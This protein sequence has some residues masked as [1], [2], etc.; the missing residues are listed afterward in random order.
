MPRVTRRMNP[1]LTT[2][3]RKVAA[4]EM[5]KDGWSFSMSELFEPTRLGDI[6]VRNKIVMA[7]LTRQRADAHGVPAPFAV[8]YYA[9]RA[10]AGLIITEGTQ[11][12][13]E[14]QGYPRTPGAHTPA[15]SAAW[16]RITDAVHA[17]GGK[18]VLQMMH[19][20]RIAHHLNRQVE[21]PPVA[22][23]A[24]RA[25]GTIWTD[26]LQQQ[27]H[28]VPRALDLAEIPRL[29]DDFVH[30]ARVA[31]EAGFDGVE[32]HA[33]N[34]YLINQFLATNANQRSDRYGG[35]VEGR[36]RLA[37]EA[38]DAIGGAIGY[39]RTGIRISPG[40]LFN[41]LVDADPRA[42][43]AALL[44]ALPTDKMAY[45]HLM[46]PDSFDPGL[47]NA[48]DV[49]SLIADIR[50]RVR[51]PIILAGGFDRARAEAA[52]AAGAGQ[53]IA[54]GRPFIANPDFVTRLKSGAPL[55]AP[56]ADLFYTPGPEGYTD[57]PALG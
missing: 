14:G 31:I 47:N 23:S 46:S 36:I 17:R 41:D 40:H 32:V 11:P 51:G 43:H 52:L 29:I 1:T 15:Q 19:A 53:A 7:P 20:G 35:S 42:T 38:V 30:S 21:G 8:D 6:V 39:G 9:Q 50:A 2:S 34:G 54:F 45:V 56:R 57:Y 55:A 13:F 12:S 28:D 24:I 49:S 4:G 3:S 5:A 33:A 44:A 22:P 26:Q 18:I 27:E 16:R 25:A 48:G 37:G 10:D